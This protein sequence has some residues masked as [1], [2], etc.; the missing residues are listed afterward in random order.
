MY[1][2]KVK[3]IILLQPTS[4]LRTIKNIKDAIKKFKNEKYDS[5]FSGYLSKKFIWS[6]IN[7]IKKYILQL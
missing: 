4:P 7:K 6:D 3:N 2:K 5:L 1:F